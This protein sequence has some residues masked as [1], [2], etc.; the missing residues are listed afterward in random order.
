MSYRSQ[1]K[2]SADPL[3][4]GAKR[5]SS[6]RGKQYQ[7]V[8]GIGDFFSLE[9]FWKEVRLI[10]GNYT[11]QVWNAHTGELTEDTLPYIE[12][13]QHWDPKGY[14][15]HLCSSGVNEFDP[16]PC[17]GCT[18]QD[19]RFSVSR[20]FTVIHLANY[21]KTPFVKN[22]E[23]VRKKGGEV[24][25]IDRECEGNNCKMCAAGDEKFFGKRSHMKLGL[26][27]FGQLVAKVADLNQ[28]CKCGGGI[29]ESQFMC[30][31]CNSI[32]IDMGDPKC[33]MT[34]REVYNARENGIHC[35]KCG[36]TVDLIPLPSCDSCEKPQPV[37]IFDVNTFVRKIDS[38]NA[39]DKRAIL[40]VKFSEPC[41]LPKEYEGPVE[42]M[43]LQAIF[44][45]KPIQDQMRD[46][47]YRGEITNVRGHKETESYGD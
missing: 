28:R 5:S 9:K 46:W 32:L 42:P 25:M 37:T 14:R 33:T 31:H 10:N 12:I 16:Q 22:G 13:K 26:Q 20:V 17:V 43:D 3:L 4:A 36:Y 19:G 6:Y 18:I 7:R 45:P 21:H 35:A 27:H 39:N 11:Q 47:N 8:K 38:G 40:D 44:T 29:V 2:K 23:I 30:P 34:D 24:V 41:D 15:S 1:L